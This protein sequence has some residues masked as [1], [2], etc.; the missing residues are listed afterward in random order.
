[1]P[2]KHR[3]WFATL[4]RASLKTARA[5]AIKEQLRRLWQLSTEA[6]AI[7]FWKSW[8]FWATHS[9]LVPV[10]SAAKKLRRHV[11]ALLNYFRCPITN[12]QAEGLN[13]RIET[14][15]RL[16]RGYRNLEHFKTAILFHCG[17]LDLQP[18]T[19]GES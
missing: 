12:A 13:G 4:K 16:A 9:R 10:I 11:A 2:R 17:G 5:W 18:I 8:Y 1:M 15:K 19:H 7:R 3:R 6:G 14:I